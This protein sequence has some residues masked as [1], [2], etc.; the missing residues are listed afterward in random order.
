MDYIINTVV[1][2]YLADYI[3]INP[4]KTKSS[5]LSG[6]VELSGVK[7]KRTLFTTLNIPYLELE[8]GYIGKIKAQL[9]LPRFY[10]YPIVV[11]I[12]QIYIKVRPK[13]VN[14]I[15]EKEILD[16]FEL[17][18]M[19]KLKEFED[20]MNVKFSNLFEDLKSKDKNGG[21]TMIENI[22][23]NLHI[24]I[25]KIVLIFDDCVSNPRHPCTYGV[26]L[27]KLFIDST[28]K[29]FT[30]IKEED[31]S[32]PFKYKKLSIKS[33]N[34]FLDK[35]NK[36]DII[37]DEKTGDITANHKIKEEMKNKL[38]ENDKKYLKD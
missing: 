12:D 11:N 36:E 25:E 15:T 32:S 26:T 2:N 16:T 30:E 19:K 9:S 22:I 35:I 4:E 23:N 3:E 27:N 7:F 10:L 38:N 21:P 6:T 5:I 20:L 37:K 34:T 17:Y 8:D 29:D 24:N 18:K 33:L 1:S 28:S 13:N 31:K 14:K